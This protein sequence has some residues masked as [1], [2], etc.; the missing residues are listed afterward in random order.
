MT[1]GQPAP[2]RPTRRA[3]AKVP[4]PSADSTGLLR[5]M[6]RRR[7][8]SVPGR[9]SVQSSRRHSMDRMETCDD[10]DHQHLEHC[11]RALAPR[12][13]DVSSIPAPRTHRL[14][15]SPPVQSRRALAAPSPRTLALRHAGPRRA[16][17]GLRMAGSGGRA[18]ACWWPAA[19]PPHRHLA[20]LR[21]LSRA[22]L[23]AAAGRRRAGA[24]S[25]ALPPA[26]DRLARRRR[27][28]STRRSTAPT[29]PTRSPRV[30]DA[31][32]HARALAAF[33]GCSYGAMVGLQFAARHPPSARHAGRDQRRATARIPMPAP[34][35]RCSGASSRSARS[36]GGSR[37]AL[38]LA[39]QLAHAQS[40]ARR[41]NSPSASTRRSRWS[42]GR[43]ALR[44]RGLP[45]GAAAATTS[46]APRPPPS[47]A[48]RNRST[49]IASTPESVRAPTTLVA[50]EEDRLVPRADLVALAERLP[51]AAPPAPAA[52]A[53]RPRR[54]P[55]GARARSRADRCAKRWPSA[56][57]C[58][59]APGG[60]R[61]SPDAARPPRAPCAP[62][63]TSDTAH[64]RGRAA[65]RAVEQFQLRRLRPEAP[66]RLHAQRQSHP[67]PARRS[68]GRS[69]RR[70]R[71]RRHRP[72]AWPPSPWCC[73]LLEPGDLLVVPHDCYG[74]SWRLFD[75]LARKEHFRLLVADLTDP[76]ALAAALAQGAEAGLDRDAVQSAAAHHRPRASSP[77]PRI[78]PARWCWSTTPSCRRRCRRR[79]RFGADLVRALDHQVHQRPQRRGRRRGDRARPRP[80]RAAGLVGERARPDRQ[81]LRQL[82]DAARPAH[83]RRAH[84]R[85]PG[86]RRARSPTLLS[87]ARR[88][89]RRALPGPGRASRTRAGRAPAARLRRHALARAARRPAGGARLRRRPALL[90]ARRIARRRRKPGRAP[91]DDDARV[92][93]RRS[94]RRR[95]HRRRP[96]AAVGR[97][98]GRRRPGRRPDPRARARIRS[99]CRRSKAV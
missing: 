18:G 68:A 42:D 79:S 16:A 8:A 95:R 24:G 75:A 83:A 39:R 25:D 61:M 91:G 66:L 90:H 21:A 65:A 67:R 55:E 5:Q 77:R 51:R 87:D 52:F 9:R 78:A 19:S 23:V 88:G 14:R 2:A 15:R 12:S 97:H 13:A 49:C 80:A 85:A 37:E 62:A 11:A 45:R 6:G 34:G 29:R 58:I 33:V 35:A 94:A 43:R 81:P 48:C 70:R 40:T 82:P 22:G 4:I 56:S 64:R 59:A 44:R 71:R 28:R 53:L 96:A 92:D 69:G 99:V 30:L 17:P 20:R 27:R 36:E 76:R 84:A 7:R 72:P 31:P 86:E 41:R 98:R 60:T 1:P 32:R 46:P 47:C 54:L 63:S 74:G 93:D 26:R 50:I 10:P 89:R 57:E 38:S 3:G 73:T